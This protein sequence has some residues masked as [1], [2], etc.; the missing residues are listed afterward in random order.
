MDLGPE[1]RSETFKIGQLARRASVSV[2]A[3]R[4]YERRGILPRPE[5]RPSGYRVYR[6]SDLDRVRMTKALQ[7]LGFTLDEVISA[8]TVFDTGTATC[9]G[10]RWRLQ[11]VL[12]RID[13]KVDELLTLRRTVAQALESCR[14]GQCPVLSVVQPA[15]RRRSR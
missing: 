14:A 9:D 8:L 1:S 12:K 2:D 15:A 4:F 13:A 11:T 5:R 6:R 10:E 3:I 7:K